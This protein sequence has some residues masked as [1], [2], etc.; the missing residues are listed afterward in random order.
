MKPVFFLD[1]SGNFCYFYSFKKRE[2]LCIS[3][4][5][6]DICNLCIEE[7]IPLSDVMDTL[8]F[9]YGEKELLEAYDDFLYFQKYGFWDEVDR[10]QIVT[11]YSSENIENS[12]QNIGTITFELTQRCNLKCTY[13]VYGELY[14]NTENNHKRDLD[15]EKA[16]AVLDYF[17]SH[18][19]KGNS[20]NRTIVL[21]FYGGEPLLKFDLMKQIVE[22]SRSLECTDIRFEYTITTNG[23]LLNKHMDFLVENEF[24]TL[25]S[26]DGDEYSSSYRVTAN[27]QNQF[28]LIYKNVIQ[29][30]KKYPIYFKYKVVFNTVLHNRNSSIT[31]LNFVKQRFGT[32]PLFST[33]STVSVNPKMKKKFEEMHKS[34]SDDVK[35]HKKDFLI[36]DI[37]RISPDINFIDKFFANILGFKT[38]SLRTLLCEDINT[39]YIPS[40]T[41]SPFSFKIFLSSD[42]KLHPCEKVGY[43]YSLG[44]VDEYNNVILDNK[45]IAELYSGIFKSV[46]EK[47]ARCYNLYS[48]S[49]CLFET[50]AICNF[51]SRETFTKRLSQYMM[52]LQEKRQLTGARYK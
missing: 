20:T 47:C 31:T 26:L 14:S 17:V 46:Q 36:E 49:T 34:L 35:Q 24:V 22:Y 8:K 32:V 2:M 30:L 4:A 9:K 3:H 39:F 41:C 52:E 43:K 1:K 45:K 44:Y 7:E 25:I 50:N 38:S 40:A 33:L 19:R 37:L 5:L 16:K 28:S 29:L 12:K 48:C 27:G 51:V 23:I 10:V 11:N 6:Y 18:I 15:F 42:G 13:C 21:G